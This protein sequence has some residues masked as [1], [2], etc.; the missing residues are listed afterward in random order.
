MEV[1]L[2][3]CSLRARA[4]WKTMA[5]PSDL[6]TKWRLSLPHLGSSAPCVKT[7]W[8]PDLEGLILLLSKRVMVEVFT[9]R[10]NHRGL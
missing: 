2:T 1:N 7:S 10:V 4:V 6:G 9:Y 5:N 3:F 8:S